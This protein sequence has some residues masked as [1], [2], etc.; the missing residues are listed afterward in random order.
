M[1]LSLLKLIQKVPACFNNYFTAMLFQC[2]DLQYYPKNLF[3]FFTD[4]EI[5]ENGYRENETISMYLNFCILGHFKC[6]NFKIPVEAFWIQHCGIFLLSDELLFSNIN[7]SFFK[8]F[9]LWG[10]VASCFHYVGGTYS[11]LLNFVLKNHHNCRPGVKLFKHRCT[12]IY[13]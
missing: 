2:S 11:I 10:W 13:T 12:V 5:A 4:K 7:I 9:G 8:R 3:F 1:L 6:L